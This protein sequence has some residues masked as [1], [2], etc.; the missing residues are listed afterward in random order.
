MRIILSM[1]LGERSY[2]PNVELAALP[3]RRTHNSVPSLPRVRSGR[4]KPNPNAPSPGHLRYPAGDRVRR[5]RSADRRARP[6][7]FAVALLL[8]A[9]VWST[10]PGA[11]TGVRLDGACIR[12]GVRHARRVRAAAR[13]RG[14]RARR[15]L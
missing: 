14:G 8:D 10:E 5:E 2:R 15:S 4:F 12:L 13:L 3:S 7:Q 9:I 6:A 11:D 1:R